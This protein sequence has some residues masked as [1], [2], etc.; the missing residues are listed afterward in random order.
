MYLRVSSHVEIRRI[1]CGI[2]VYVQSS[3]SSIGFGEEAKLE[4]MFAHSST[5]VTH[6]VSVF[7]ALLCIFKYF[8]IRACP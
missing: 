8:W 7:S 5:F 3:A 6:I 1:T 2:S 4:H